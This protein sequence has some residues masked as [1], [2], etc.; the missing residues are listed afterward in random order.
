[1]NLVCKL[2]ALRKC[3][4]HEALEAMAVLALEVIQVRTQNSRNGI[5]NGN[6]TTMKFFVLVAMMNGKLACVAASCML[7]MYRI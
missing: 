5:K 7:I 6:Q 4:L 1:M 2:K 3:M